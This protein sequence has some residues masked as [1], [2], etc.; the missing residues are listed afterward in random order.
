MSFILALAF[1]F[2]IGSV[3][4]WGLE[5]VFR[6]TVHHKWINPGFLT[7][8]CLPLYGNGLV[9][10][11]V[12]CYY[13][14]LI[15]TGRIWLNKLLLV[16]LITAVMTLLE[17]ITGIISIKFMK[18]RLWD[19]SR[20][21][22]NIQ[23]I[24]CPLFSFF[25]GVI[26]AAYYFFVHWRVENALFWLSHNLAFSFFIGMFYGVFVIDF[27]YS[28]RLITKIKKWAEETNIVVRY[29]NLK[30]SVYD[31]L[32]QNQ[33]KIHFLFPVHSPRSIREELENY[34]KTKHVE[35]FKQKL[36]KRRDT[37]NK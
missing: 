20:R 23:G 27:A 6:R 1:I 4:G 3:L 18:V 16:L 37:K 5:V 34:M 13:G 12:I 8:P 14:E 32:K 33:E 25:W 29:E 15:N 7:G 11:F 24:I 17:Y 36:K 21:W 19:Y 30:E 35:S 22:G 26:G 9:L 31:R 28:L 10:M 2:F